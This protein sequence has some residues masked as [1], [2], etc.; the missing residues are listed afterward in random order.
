MLSPAL[1]RL[2]D[3]LRPLLEQRLALARGRL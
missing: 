2:R 3:H 1:V